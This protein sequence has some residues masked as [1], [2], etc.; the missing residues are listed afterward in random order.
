MFKKIIALMLVCI[1]SALSLTVFTACSDDDGDN[2]G[3]NT[4][5][6][7]LAAF[8]CVYGVASDVKESSEK[9]DIKIG[10]ILIGDSTEGYT[11]AHIIGI[12]AACEALG[13]DHTKEENVIWKYKVL[14][15]ITTFGTT[16]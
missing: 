4:D 1:L 5:P 9:T 7:A 12:Q 11:E 13:I 15:S 16:L 14:E 3:F 2:S 10:C 8:G 6:N